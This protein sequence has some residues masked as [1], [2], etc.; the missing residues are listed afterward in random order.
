MLQ[1]FTLRFRSHLFETEKFKSEDTYFRLNFFFLNCKISTLTLWKFKCINAEEMDRKKGKKQKVPYVKRLNF[2]NIILYGADTFFSLISYL[3]MIACTS[4]LLNLVILSILL[5]ILDFFVDRYTI[6]YCGY[7]CFEWPA[8]YTTEF[9]TTE[10]P[11]C[12]R[13]GFCFV[14]AVCVQPWC[15]LTFLSKWFVS[16]SYC[17]LWSLQLQICKSPKM[18]NGPKLQV[19]LCCATMLRKTLLIRCSFH[20]FNS[21][22][23][24][25]KKKIIHI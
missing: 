19:C 18:S 24:K 3:L 16:P 5:P 14:L 7:G 13:G 25:P 12:F 15:V 6:L 20:S 4:P 1:F 8:V 23:L 21:I 17:I 9:C 11:S 22:Q 10:I 2:F